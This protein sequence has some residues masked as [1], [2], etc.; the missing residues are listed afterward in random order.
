MITKARKPCSYSLPVLVSLGVVGIQDALVFS[1]D[2]LN[3]YLIKFNFTQIHTQS[4]N[5]LL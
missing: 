2:S 3:T 5:N 4:Q 1:N